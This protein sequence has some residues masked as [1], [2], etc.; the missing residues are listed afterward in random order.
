MRDGIKGPAGWLAVLV[1]V[2]LSGAATW[3]LLAEE[4]GQRIDINIV[5]SGYQY[6]QKALQPNQPVV[7]RLHNQD[8]IEHGFTSVALQNTAMQVETAEGTVI[9]R[10]ITAV[11]I[12]PGKE[13]SIRLLAPLPGQYPFQCD[14][15]PTMK[16]ELFLLSIN[17]A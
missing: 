8:T 1:V 15:H 17:A 14:L 12:A 10:G 6:T 3:P 7:I 2:A 16:G 11:H 13:L 4:S 9:G 5:R